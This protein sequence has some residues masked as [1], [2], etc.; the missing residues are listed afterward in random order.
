[1]SQQEQVA[2]RFQQSLPVLAT[3]ALG[4]WIAYESFTVEDFLMGNGNGV[5]GPGET[6]DLIVTLANIGHDL[7]AA[8]KGRFVLGLGSA[9]TNTTGMTYFS[10]VAPSDRRGVSVSIF[11]ALSIGASIYRDEEATR[12]LW[13]LGVDRGD[14]EE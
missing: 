2:G 14:G 1:M 10:S 7:N 5:A 12:S 8:S 9:L 6:V 11:A 4:L 3:L 13:W